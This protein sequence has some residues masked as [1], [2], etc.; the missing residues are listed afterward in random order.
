MAWYCP[1]YAGMDYSLPE[2][3]FIIGLFIVIFLVFRPLKSDNRTCCEMVPGIVYGLCHSDQTLTSEL[4]RDPT[5][6][7]LKTF[8]NLYHGCT[9][10]SDEKAAEPTGDAEDS[11]Q[12][13]YECGHWGDAKPSALFL[14]VSKAWLPRQTLLHGILTNDACH[15]ADIPRFPMPTRKESHGG[16]RLSAADGQPRSPP[17]DHCR[18]PARHL[19][20][21]VQLHRPSGKRSLPSDQFLDPFTRIDAGNQ[22]VPGWTAWD[23]SGRQS[24]L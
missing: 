19:P 21:Y 15:F 4:A 7:P 18:P 12:K 13:A 14:Q 16:R 20:P 22:C 17:L 1:E 24:G 9:Q 10:K 11:L 5:Q 23:K 6:C 8:H 3:L 2:I